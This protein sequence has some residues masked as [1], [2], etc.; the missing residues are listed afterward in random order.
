MPLNQDQVATVKKYLASKKALR[1][2]FVCEADNQW[3]FR[4]LVFMPGYLHGVVQNGLGVT[5]VLIE[6][7]TCGS[8]L[9]LSA[10]RV[11]LV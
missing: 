10:K 3:A 2:C 4:E 9:L 6:C 7:E 1:F 11:G 8:Q 5:S